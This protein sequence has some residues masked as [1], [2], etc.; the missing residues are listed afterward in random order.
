MTPRSGMTAPSAAALRMRRSRERRR[1]GDAMVSLD[2]GPNA[3]ADLADLSRSLTDA[4]RP[5][6]AQTLGGSGNGADQSTRRIPRVAGKPA[7]QPRG[8]DTGREAASDCRTRPRGAADD[9]PA[10]RLRPRLTQEAF[11]HTTNRHGHIAELD[12]RNYLSV[13][14]EQGTRL[15]AWVPQR[16]CRSSRAARVVAPSPRPA[17]RRADGRGV[18][19]RCARHRWTA[20]SRGGRVVERAP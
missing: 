5:A 9:R 13:Q 14:A 16:D 7:G 4:A 8:I 19:A 12:A 10:T 3:I 18:R 1:Q 15:P 2:V 6:A 11:D 20:P 17:R